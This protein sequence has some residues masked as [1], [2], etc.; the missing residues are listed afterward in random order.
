MVAAKHL[1]D[2]AF[3]KLRVAPPTEW[4]DL[5]AKVGMS[6]RPTLDAERCTLTS[7]LERSDSGSRG[8]SQ[9]TRPRAR[10]TLRAPPPPA[11]EQD[12][13]DLDELLRELGE[14]PPQAKTRPKKK[15][16]P[17]QMKAVEHDSGEGSPAS[18]TPCPSARARTPVCYVPQAV[19]DPPT[20]VEVCDTDDDT[21]DLSSQ[22]EGSDSDVPED[23]P[24]EV[25]AAP[26]DSEKS[27]TPDEV[28]DPQDSA[29]PR[30][31]HVDFTDSALVQP[32]TS[33]THPACETAELCAAME[34]SGSQLPFDTRL[35]F[36]FL[37]EPFTQQPED[38]EC[39]LAPPESWQERSLVAACQPNCP[40]L[41]RAIDVVWVPVPTRLLRDVQE[42]L[43][44][45]GVDTGSRL[46]VM[47]RSSAIICTG[48]G[49]TVPLFAPALVQLPV[50]R[51]SGQP[52]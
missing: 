13:R 17:G 7:L 47:E 27:P 43:E 3:R 14:A 39:A 20:P 51:E 35:S 16:A 19:E 37:S 34:G 48:N 42:I 29:T 25:S 6:F 40:P 26:D 28:R 31:S 41:E 2:D 49:E 45:A 23:S 9:R 32:T 22:V 50:T 38:Q 4:E 36:H 33:P 21:E 46:S 8:E 5:L 52:H 11:P 1:D 15:G 12:P 44:K 30:R 10:R 18:C 24:D